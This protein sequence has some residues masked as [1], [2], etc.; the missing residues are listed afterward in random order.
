[1]KRRLAILLAGVGLVLAACTLPVARVMDG[2]PAPADPPLIQDARAIF[3]GVCFNYWEAQVNRLFVL[4]SPFA[5]IAFYNEVDESGLCRFPVIREAFDFTTGRLLIGAVNV[6]DG[7]RA[8][9]DPL[10]L[11]QDD[12]A[13]TLT[14]YVRWGVEGDCPYRLARPLWVSVPAPPEGYEIRLV[15]EP[16]GG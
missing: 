15:P 14:L 16:A 13:R 3:G 12:E 2:P 1:M 11:V 4:D 10:R 7:C 9:T 5:H 6:A 8:T